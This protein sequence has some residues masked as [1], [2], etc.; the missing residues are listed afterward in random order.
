M[1]PPVK[2]DEVEVPSHV[3]TSIAPF[4]SV[5]LFS[6]CSLTAPEVTPPTVHSHSGML[7]FFVAISLN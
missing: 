7:L 5:P 3:V 1:C 4:A 2:A 6:D